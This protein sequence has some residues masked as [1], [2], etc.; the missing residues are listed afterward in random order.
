MCPPRGARGIQTPGPAECGARVSGRAAAG[1]D[2]SLDLILWATSVPD[3]AIHARR[4]ASAG[5]HPRQ[6]S[7]AGARSGCGLP[8]N[9][10]RPVRGTRSVR[11]VHGARH[12]RTIGH[13]QGSTRLAVPIIEQAPELSSRWSRT[14]LLALFVKELPWRVAEHG[15]VAA[16]RG[17]CG[18]A[19][20]ARRAVDAGGASGTTY[21]RTLKAIERARE[22]QPR[23][24]PPRRSAACGATGARCRRRRPPTS[25]PP[26]ASA[27]A[28]AGTSGA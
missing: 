27:C 17:R 3:N 28:G 13:P 12:G 21:T 25:T 18:A 26:A 20:L 11:R 5:F 1:F 8:E 10:G 7:A 22:A 4:K 15:V 2:R 19:R 24:L 6:R 23:V 9:A 16:Q 14:G